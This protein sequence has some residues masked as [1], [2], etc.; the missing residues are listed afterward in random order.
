MR[1]R[2]RDNEPWE[3]FIAIEIERGGVTVVRP[4]TD[5]GYRA[6]SG[7]RLFLDNAHGSNTA[8]ADSDLRIPTSWASALTTGTVAFRFRPFGWAANDNARHQLDYLR[9]GADASY[10]LLV[11]KQT[12]NK[13]YAAT[14]G[15]GTTTIA[16][17]ALS[18]AAG[19][20]HSII[21]R[22]TQGGAGTL[23]LNHDGTAV[24]Q[25]AQAQTLAPGA[26]FCPSDF[27]SGAALGP[28]YTGPHLL[29]GATRWA[30]ADTVEFQANQTALW[31]NPPAL[32]DWL[33]RK[34]YAATTLI[35]PLADNSL[36]YIVRG[37]P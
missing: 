12:D 23:D 5:A 1:R 28:T 7:Q 2:H 8:A 33:W 26:F 21:V 17:A 27:A 11:Y 15:A 4:T 37:K 31:T 13:L 6:Y 36:S 34:G 29:S 24:A 3:R 10:S 22:W 35:T 25:V 9:D 14:K 32:V 18:W 19:T 30:D 20:Q 16:S